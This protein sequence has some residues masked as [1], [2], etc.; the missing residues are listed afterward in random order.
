MMGSRILNR[1][2]IAKLTSNLNSLCIGPNQKLNGFSLS[3][4]VFSQN[5]PGAIPEISQLY[6]GLSACIGD[7][8]L[9]YA[10]GLPPHTGGQ[11]LV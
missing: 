2:L 9:A 5:S 8:P 6:H 11:T 1:H 3:L 4:L 10:H 7:N